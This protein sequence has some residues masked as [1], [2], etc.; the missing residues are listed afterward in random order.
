MTDPAAASERDATRRKIVDL[1]QA[2]KILRETR[3][4]VCAPQRIL[5]LVR[6]LV[7]DAI[8]IRFEHPHLYSYTK[9][10]H[11]T[12]TVLNLLLHWILDAQRADGGVAAYYSLLTGYS[13][14]YPEVTGYTIPTLYDS[15]QLFPNGA[16]NRELI[17]TAER[18]TTW[19]L[20]LQMPNGAF[21]AGLHGA[22]TQPS[23]F[24]TGQI[25]QG[26][27]RA[28]AETNRADI[29]AAAILAGDWLIEMQQPDG[30]WS[31]IGAYQS[32]THTYYSMVAWPL[33]LLSQ[34]TLNLRYG[35][36]A[37][38]NLDWALLH[39][40]PNGWIDGINLQGHPIYLH[41]IAYVL[42][43]ALECA[44]L[45]Q[46]N[47]AIETV[48]RSA[49]VL[50]RRFEANKFLCGAY[51]EDFENGKAFAC[52]TGNA[53][54][55]CVWLRLFEITGDLRYLNAAL[56]MNEMLKELIPMR[57]KQGIAGGV[58][59]SYPIWSR[60]QP[61]RY[62]SWG[63]KFLA[64]ALLLEQRIKPI[65]EHSAAEVLSCAS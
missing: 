4:L 28:H 45:R 63:C 11:E 19:L 31:G 49:W 56:K 9:T 32:A 46:R 26:L 30:S 43:G 8:R 51:N 50:L 55:S 2:A 48:A 16:S 44:V 29:L 22:S 5:P 33:A 20:S 1:D 60:Y 25:L 64:D 57:G 12:A 3:G 36:A 62:I 34:E 17:A 58:G 65:F 59:G 15:A 53:Q 39:F 6:K 27:I 24:N 7:S 38:K 47:D 37:D 54:M 13:S 41:F 21:P 18:A 14:S 10:R 42:Q 35:H 52:L 23:I 40:Q 61:L